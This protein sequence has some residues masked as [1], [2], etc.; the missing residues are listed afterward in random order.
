MPQS[1]PF[2]GLHIEQITSVGLVRSAVSIAR[3]IVERSPQS[4]ADACRS[5]GRVVPVTA[6]PTTLQSQLL[7]SLQPI[8]PFTPQ[9]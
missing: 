2:P 8:P 3:D 9:D 7:L 1:A 5:A 6:G 4:A